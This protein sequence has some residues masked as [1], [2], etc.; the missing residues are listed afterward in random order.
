MVE[1]KYKSR[2][3]DVMTPAEISAFSKAL[4]LKIHVITGWVIPT[5]EL[6]TILC[7]Q[8][9]KKLTEDYSVLNPDEIEFAFRSLGLK[10]EDWGKN[11][12]LNL[13]DKVLLPYLDERF[14]VSEK[15]AAIK[16]PP[17]AVSL[18][19]QMWNC[20]ARHEIFK[21]LLPT[22]PTLKLYSLVWQSRKK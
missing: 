13:V 22:I 4:L 21:T 11:L 15:E 6:M 14:S 10:L 18:T 7:D 17:P 9:A 8:F 20:W 1:L 16:E 3:L 19:S 5:G 12:N 2:R